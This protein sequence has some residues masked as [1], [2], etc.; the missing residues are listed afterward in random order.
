MSRLPPDISPLLEHVR[1]LLDSYQQ[2]VGEELIRRT[3]SLRDD[4]DALFSSPRVVLSHGIEEDPILNYGNQAALSL[5]EMTWDDF[6]S[7][8][9]RLT[10]ELEKRAERA[11]RLQEV[12]RHGWVS[13]YRGIRLSRSGRRFMVEGA[14]VWTLLDHAGHS[15]G[16]AATF[17]RWAYV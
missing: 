9:S 13:D 11:L 7:T 12:T 2:W 5:W 17:T 14:T 6:T 1:R 4:A 15:C 16:Q 8:P 3:G 10:A